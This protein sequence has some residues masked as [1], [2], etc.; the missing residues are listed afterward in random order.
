MHKSSQDRIPNPTL[1]RTPATTAKHMTTALPARRR[2][3]QRW[4]L[5]A[6]RPVAF[7]PFVI[8]YKGTCRACVYILEGTG[9]E[10]LANW[11]G[12]LLGMHIAFRIA[13]LLGWHP[14]NRPLRLD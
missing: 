10:H 11:T 7:Y 13:R 12:N 8:W 9:S 14:F 2:L 4:G 3:T 6:T 5:T 1:N